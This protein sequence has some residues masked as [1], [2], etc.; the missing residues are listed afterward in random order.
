MEFSKKLLE[1]LDK[2]RMEFNTEEVE[3]FNLFLAIRNRNDEVR[4]H[5]RFLASL[6]DPN[7]P[8][9]LGTLPLKTF[10]IAV[11][12]SPDIADEKRLQITPNYKEKHEHRNIDI[13]IATCKHAII[14][15]NKIYH[16]DTNYDKETKAKGQRGQLERYYEIM[17][18][19]GQ[20]YV[21]D[22][23]EISVVYLTPEGKMPG[24]ESTG[25]KNPKY[26]KLRDKVIPI[27]YGSSIYGWLK[28]LLKEIPDSP[29][30]FS[31]IQYMDIIDDITNTGGREERIKLRD[32]L[33]R[34]SDKDIDNLHYLLKNEKHV[35]WHIADE[36]FHEMIRECPEGL[37]V[38]SLEVDEDDTFASTDPKQYD[39][40]IAKALDENIHKDKKNPTFVIYYVGAKNVRVYLAMYDGELWIGNINKYFRSSTHRYVLL[41]QEI[42]DWL[43]E[44]D[45]NV[46]KEYSQRQLFIQEQCID[47]STLSSDQSRLTL[48]MA[49][50]NKRIKIVREILKEL[51]FLSRELENMI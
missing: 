47:F 40:L 38:H 29:I 9:G 25:G 13:L 24:Q 17:Q 4:L 5:S 39:S 51:L 44:N 45:Y 46:Q 18:K 6:L 1:A 10:L 27:G 16:H 20:D 22:E 33:G 31:I 19:N 21:Y 3:S 7:A 30:K 49:N 2:V 36:F 37:V 12:L 28:D 15:E 26:P 34:M 8:H 50:P 35:C 11:G 42:R 23:D 48:E 32:V 43:Y 41:P 14:I